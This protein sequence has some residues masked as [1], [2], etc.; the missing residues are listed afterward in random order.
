MLNPYNNIAV[1]ELCM[2][3]SNTKTY[4]TI[5]SFVCSERMIGYRFLKSKCKYI[6]FGLNAYTE[7]HLEVLTL[8]I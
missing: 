7:I 1:W 2:V 3:K 6:N 8:I 4:L 5:D